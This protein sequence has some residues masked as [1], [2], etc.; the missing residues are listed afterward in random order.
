MASLFAQCGD[1]SEVQICVTL[2]S[3][4]QKIEEA[5]NPPA[6]EQGMV[7]RHVLDSM[8]AF[9]GL[10]QAPQKQPKLI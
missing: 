9:V 6:L 8:L 4:D 10:T 7:L 3:L 2:S 5:V 1:V